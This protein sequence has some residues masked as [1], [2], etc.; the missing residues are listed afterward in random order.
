MDQKH[1]T[2]EAL[3]ALRETGL[4]SLNKIEKEAGVPQS[5]LVKAITRGQLTCSGIDRVGP[6]LQKIQEILNQYFP[7]GKPADASIH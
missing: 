6:V 4:V 3:E 5:T 7:E 2:L 1:P